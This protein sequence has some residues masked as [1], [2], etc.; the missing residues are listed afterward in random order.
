MRYVSFPSKS[1]V[2]LGALLFV[3]LAAPLHAQ[4]AAKGDPAQG[5]GPLP[6]NVAPDP[7]PICTD[8]PTKATTTCTVPAGAVQIE[9]DLINW[10]R[11]TQDGVRTDTLLYTNPTVKYGIGKHTD[12]QINIAPYETVRSRM[13][14]GS[15]TTD[16]GIGDLYVRAKQKLTVDKSKTQVSLVGFV[17]APTAG[18]VLGNGAWEGGAIVPVNVP[19]PFK[20]T[21]TTS[22]ELDIAGDQAVSG[23]HHAELA[24]LIN[25]SHPVG[26]NATVYAELWTKESFEPRNNSQQYSADVAASYQLTKTLQLDA[27]AYIGLNRETP[28]LQ[29]YTGIST[30]F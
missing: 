4:E 10:T 11:E 19:L 2:R 12:I 6:P 7:T 15:V 18:S 28:G 17:K 3:A 16:R 1:A 8:R 27:A 30:R 14:D 20:F 25:L 23:G 29:L 24:N 9:T 26:K 13:P 5:T 22:P 21:L